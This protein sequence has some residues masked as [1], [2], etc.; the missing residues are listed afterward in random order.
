MKNDR[1]VFEKHNH[2]IPPKKPQKSRL[3]HCTCR[4]VRIEGS[5]LANG[6]HTVTPP[7]GFGSSFL[8]SP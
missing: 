2:R 5:V 1:S 4:L 8:D 3:H 7:P 6:P